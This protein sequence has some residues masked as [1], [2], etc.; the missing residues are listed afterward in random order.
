MPARAVPE[1]V[2]EALKAAV[3]PKGWIAAEAEKTPYLVDA[4]ELFH[5]KTPL[6]LR[7]ASTGEVAE[8]VR[9]CADAGVGI[10]P[11]GGNTGYVGGSV[12]GEEGGEL[13]VS[14]GRM[15]R[16][17]AIDPLD[18]TIT[19]EAGCILAEVQ[20]AAADVDRLFPLSLAAEGSCQIGGNLSTNAGGT[21][22]LRYGNARDLV[23]GLEVVLPDGTVWDGLRRLRK[24]NR[25]YDLKQLFLGA[26][27]TLGIIT[28]AVLK[29]FPQPSESCTALVAVAD[30]AAATRLLARFRD[31]TGDVVT[32]FE[33]LNRVCM[34][35]VLEHLPG[36]TDPF[37][38]PHEHYVLVDLASGRGCG[39]LRDLAEHV[40]GEAFEA[41]EALD[42]VIAAS[43]AQ[44]E[45]LWALR[46]SIPEAQKHAGGC[47]KH[48]VSVPVSRVPEFL[49]KATAL[50]EQT[51][52]GVRVAPF[53]H[54]GDGNV[55]FNLTQPR[56]AERAAFL[57]HSDSITDA[58]HALAA[59]LDGSFSAEHGI[60]R[61]KRNDLRRYKAPVE[62]SLMDTLKKAIDPKGIMNPHKVL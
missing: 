9:I 48:D 61:L 18:F 62:L 59:E 22:V 20:R 33:Y 51:I 55:H 36:N 25:G 35:L 3:G 12:P 39:G 42:A 1:R 50:A 53:G 11:Q 49:A 54:L 21:T 41:G 2:I 58:V 24:D 26:E 4:R 16:V 15:N 32:S 28:A 57:A 6:V 34:E 13:L 43:A 29:L 8:I 47:I 56:Q 31:R 14:L 46:E 52:T 7:P 38:R 19:V 44:G 30:P 10:V 37:D 45:R 5:G 27:G 60:G 17:R 40:L 23:L